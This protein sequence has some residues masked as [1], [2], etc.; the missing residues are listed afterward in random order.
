MV[1]W[2]VSNNIQKGEVIA[3]FN[4][5]KVESFALMI[6]ALKLGVIY[7]NLD[8]TSPEERLRKIVSRC[9]PVHLFY[10]DQ[11]ASDKAISLHE[12]NTNLVSTHFAALLQEQKT[13][14]PDEET[15]KVCADNGAYI[16]FTS[17]STGFPKGAVISH[18]NLLNFVDWAQ[19]TYNISPED[20]LT[21][22]N[23]MYFDNS[24][25]DFY[26]SIFNGASMA[27]FD[28]IR[29]IKPQKVVEKLDE[30]KA[31][32]W[33]SVPTLLVFLLTLKALDLN[34]WQSL[35]II[36]FGGEGFPKPKLKQLFDMFSHRIKLI[37][38]YGPTECTCICSSYEVNINDFDNLQSFAPLGKIAPNFDYLIVDENGRRSKQG[39]LYLG[40]P[41]VGLGYFNDIER[42]Q[43]SFIQD[44]RVS[45]F[46]KLVYKTG[47]LVEES[48]NGT[49]FILGR[50]DNQIKH[51]GYRIELEEIEAG[52]STLQYVDEVGVVYEDMGNGFGQIKAFLKLNI[53]K[54]SDT[55]KKDIRGILS[56]Y[57]IPRTIVIV[58]EIPKNNNGKIDRNALKGIK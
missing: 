14:Q 13:T 47:D 17:G 49:I 4:T 34:S 16:M 22:V 55:I 39:E 31:T 38:V 51:L 32:I 56:S 30:V 40:G 8:V 23:P 45:N 29:L 44:E 9:E 36:S 50:A 15:H 54:T 48:D 5:K 33:F 3:I 2:L 19:V 28:A 41:Q 52:F 20:V 18:Q 10:D 1:W 7:V 26:A 11:A 35:R 37:N 53:T 12:N 57:M 24:V 46:Q 6:A 25:F 58:D 27:A 21:N 42:T 43:Q